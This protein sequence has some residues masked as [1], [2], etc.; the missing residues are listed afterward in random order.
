ML[1]NL[2]ALCVL[3]A[4]ALPVSTALAQ[5]AAAP[6]SA[7]QTGEAPVSAAVTP[8][9][10]APAAAPKRCDFALTLQSDEIF[11]HKKSVQLSVLNDKGKERIDNEVIAKLAN[12]AKVDLIVVSGHTDLS[13]SHAQAQ[14]LSEKNA[15]AVVAYLASKGLSAPMDTMGMGKTQQIKA[16]DDK[17]P[18]A[19]LAECLAPNRRIVVEG[20]G[21]AK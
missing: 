5:T 8:P 2:T 9:A 6:A 15:D 19:K 11:E 18:K 21:L 3:A 4:F 16:C 14:K 1:K 12:C 10:P 17:L 13:A 20:R 7:A